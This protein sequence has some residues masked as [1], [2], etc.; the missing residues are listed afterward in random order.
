MTEV[1]E[2]EKLIEVRDLAKKKLES[3][4]EP[5]RSW[6]QYWELINTIDAILSEQ[7]S[8]TLTEY[9]LLS[10]KRLI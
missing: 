1:F 6:L 9:Q 10:N 2:K 7:G 3:G 4:N 8:A 5:P